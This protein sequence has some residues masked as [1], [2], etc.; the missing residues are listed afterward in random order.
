MTVRVT[1]GM[2]NMC[3]QKLLDFDDVFGVHEFID[4]KSAEK[5]LGKL[6]T[7]FA[8]WEDGWHVTAVF[9]AGVPLCLAARVETLAPVRPT[10][11]G[12]VS[13]P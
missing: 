6:K 3:G 7:K 12:K 4:M 10:K 11:P 1:V 8:P 13:V 5:W 9:K 2:A